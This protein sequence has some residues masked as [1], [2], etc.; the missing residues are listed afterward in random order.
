MASVNAT[1][2]ASSATDSAGVTNLTKQE[3]TAAP[4]HLQR[5]EQHAAVSPL[6]S[7]TAAYPDVRLP[8]GGPLNRVRYLWANAEDVDLANLSTTTLAEVADAA[9]CGI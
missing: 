7:T 9:Q 4:V 5:L 6:P 1:I 8:G 3:R 2:L